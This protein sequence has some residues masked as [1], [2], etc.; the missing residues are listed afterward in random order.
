MGQNSQI[1]DLFMDAYEQHADAIFRHYYFRVY[2][3]EK[4]QDLVQEV[5]MRVWD[6]VREGH[7]VRNIRAFLYKLANN[8]IIDEVRK[9]QPG[10]L[11]AL[12]EKGWEPPASGRNMEEIL[13]GEEANDLLQQ[14]EP[15]YCQVLTMRYIDDLAPREIAEILEET[16]DAVSV[17]IHRA[18][19]KVRGMIQENPLI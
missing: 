15:S 2:S 10:S 13:A 1:H 14:L 8:V 11:E 19:E 3:R 6:Y 7:E 9:K 4:A 12:R 16:P 17:R 18:L 5:F